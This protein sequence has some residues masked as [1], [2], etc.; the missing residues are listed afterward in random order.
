M[1]EP[2]LIAV[3]KIVRPHG[4]RGAVKVYPYGES[5]ATREVGDK[6]LLQPA[7][8][9][10][11]RD[12]LT[13]QSLKPQGKFLL[14]QFKELTRIE[15]AQTVVG[16]EVFLPEDRLPTPEE[17]EYY[18]F[19]LIGLRVE[20]LQGRPVG[21]LQGIIETGG[22]DIYSV[23]NEGREILIPAVDE[24]I[25]EIDLERGLMV[26]DPPEGLLDDL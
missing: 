8:D 13:L 21:I 19:Q 9:T 26:I 14:V 12:D 17:G 20:T 4:L 22:H 11:K 7:A 24:I 23:E 10:L 25:T 16:Q 18:H 5:L 3:G 15:E 1:K 2:H 6:L